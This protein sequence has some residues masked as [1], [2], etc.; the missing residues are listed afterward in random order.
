MKSQSTLSDLEVQVQNRLLGR[1][2]DFRLLAGERGLVLRGQSKTYYAKQ[3]AQHSVMQATRM[4][5]L[6]NEIVVA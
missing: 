4:P 3:L 1:V 2:F 6:A 5:I